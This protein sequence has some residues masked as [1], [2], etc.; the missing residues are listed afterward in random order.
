MPLALPDEPCRAWTNDAVTGLPTTRRGNDAIQVYVERL[1][2]L[3]HF[4]AT[5]KSDGAKEMAECFVHT[6]VRA[7]GVPDTI[8]SDRD[9]RFTANY[10]AELTRLL[11]VKVNMSTARHPQTDGQSEREIKTL[12]TA[13]RAYCNDHQNDWDEYLD[14]LELGF[15]SAVQSSSQSSPY[16]LLYGMKARLP[17]DVA[18]SSLAPRNP[19]AVDRATRMRSALKFARGRLL[20][21]QSNQIRNASRRP[22]TFNVGESVLLLTEGLTIRGYDNKLTSRFAGPFVITAVVNA[23]AYT[24]ALPPQLKALHSTFNIDKLKRYVETDA[25]ATR[26]RQLTRPPPTAVADSN[27][28]EEWEVERITAQR[29]AGKRMQF[30]VRWK[31]YP[32]EESTWE[33]RS[34]LTDGAAD[35]LRDWE[36]E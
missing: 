31:G 4:V 25:F 28:D 11:G 27:G 3:K 8:I 10:Y 18:M 15:N 14:M 17:I 9:P 23:N 30:L 12:V 35:A 2:K 24:L 5:K 21:A 26:P 6:V 19:A 20:I 29:Y 16:E 7:H 32:I 34:R 1:T 13:L 22:A 36:G 33:S